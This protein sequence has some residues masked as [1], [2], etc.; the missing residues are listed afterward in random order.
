[1]AKEK[2]K[3]KNKLTPSWLFVIWAFGKFLRCLT[4]FI[5]YTLAVGIRTW[6][7]SFR[8]SE[9][10]ICE[11]KPKKSFLHKLSASTR[12]CSGHYKINRDEFF[13]YHRLIYIVLDLARYVCTIHMFG[14]I[15]HYGPN[16][17]SVY[18]YHN[19]NWAPSPMIS[20]VKSSALTLKR[21]NN[22]L[23]A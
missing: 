4:V 14:S 17:L 13:A 7:R 22:S 21:K 10:D 8:L 1:M 20:G 5:P 12:I 9:R 2:E 15:C 18:L 23:L 19:S 3:E 16:M 11:P 6:I